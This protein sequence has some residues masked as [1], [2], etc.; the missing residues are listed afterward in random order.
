MGLTRHRT[1][2]S[3]SS[4]P[5]DSTRLNKRPTTCCVAFL[6]YMAGSNAWPWSTPL[7]ATASVRPSTYRK[8]AD[9]VLRHGDPDDLARHTYLHKRAVALNRPIR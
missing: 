6:R 8:A 2:R 9:F 3:S 7:A 4:T 1:A 5:G